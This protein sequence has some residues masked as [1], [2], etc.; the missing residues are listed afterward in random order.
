MFSY[1]LVVGTVALP[2]GGTALD[3]D[4]SVLGA[5]REVALMVVPCLV[6]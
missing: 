1:G 3:P 5:V 2:V 4:K 6:P